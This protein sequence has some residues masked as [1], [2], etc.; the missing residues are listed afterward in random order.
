MLVIK[1][2]LAEVLIE[3]G[4]EAGETP[5]R[6][7]R[8]A[9]I[10]PEVKKAPEPAPQPVKVAP[11]A[12][13]STPAAPAAPSWEGFID[14]CFRSKPVVGVIMESVVEWTLPTPEAN[15][16]KLGFREGDQAKATQ[17]SQKLIKEQILKAL[18]E[19]FKFKC[20][21]EVFFS[22][23]SGESMAERAIREKSEAREEK[24]KSIHSHAVLMEA[25]SLFGVE[26]SQI[27]LMEND[28]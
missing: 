10:E 26:L 17:L 3:V 21:L 20:M 8:P 18:E 15:L 2:S 24:L 27:E 4:A 13:V 7:V 11:P 5:R 16:C 6:S 23:E 1:T 28:Q 14:Y 9:V 12:I 25:K 22:T 19:Y